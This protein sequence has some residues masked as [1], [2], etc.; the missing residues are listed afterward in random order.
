MNPHEAEALVV[1]TLLTLDKAMYGVSVETGL[2]PEHFE[3]ARLGVIYQVMV[4]LDG[5]SG[6]F[7]RVSVAARAQARGLENA[8]AIVDELTRIPARVTDVLRAAAVIRD[9]YL[10]RGLRIVAS[11]LASGASEP[12][13]AIERAM[14]SLDAI[15][16]D[17]TAKRARRADDVVREVIEHAMTIKAENDVTG[18]P[19]GFDDLDKLTGGFQ[20]GTFWIVAARP[21]MGKSAWIVQAGT[22]AAKAGVPTAI[23]SLEMIEAEI[24]QRLVANL[25]RLPAD[26]LR[27]GSPSPGTQRRMLSAGAQVDGLPLWLDDTT[28]LSIGD[29]RSKVRRLHARHGLGLVIV[30]YLQLLRMVGPNRNDAVGEVSRGLKVLANDL[31]IPVIALSQLSREVEKRGATASAKRPQL[32]DLRDSGNLEQDAN[33]VLFL[34]REGYYD[35]E[36][37]DAHLCELIV[38]KHRAGAVTGDRQILLPWDG[39]TMRFG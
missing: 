31:E 24:G 2:R 18:V 10:G 11:E 12:R 3:A 32:S 23:F 39:A 16:A 27:R 28:D 26:T 34:F 5:E 20:P 36:C 14:A 1:G 13:A 38:A 25:G 30:D 6:G 35:P 7:D 19:S 29:L 22:N 21:G 4:E 33:G 15:S 17:S 8:P 37:A 9:A